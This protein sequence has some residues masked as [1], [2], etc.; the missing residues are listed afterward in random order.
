MSIVIEI[1]DFVVCHFHRELFLILNS[2]LG[3]FVTQ[4]VGTDFPADLGT[5]VSKSIGTDLPADLGK[6]VA[7]LVGKGL[8]MK[9][10][11]PTDFTKLIR[12]G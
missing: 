12:L 7:K 5:F 11:A 6:F 2:V 8:G 4:L 1:V 9:E 3:T 10:K